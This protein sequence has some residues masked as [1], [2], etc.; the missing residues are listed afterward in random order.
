MTG[1]RM[2][3]PIPLFLDTFIWRGQKQLVIKSN[4][5]SVAAS[6]IDRNSSQSLQFVAE[7]QRFEYAES[8]SLSSLGDGVIDLRKSG[9]RSFHHAQDSVQNVGLLIIY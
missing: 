7:I 6:K 2:S 4:T 1:V 5:S 8:P 3:R 9:H